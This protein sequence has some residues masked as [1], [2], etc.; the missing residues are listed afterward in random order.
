MYFL[1]KASGGFTKNLKKT[2]ASCPIIFPGLTD[3]EGLWSFVCPAG[4]YLY[5]DGFF[6]VVVFKCKKLKG[7]G[8]KA[9]TLDG[10]IQ[11]IAFG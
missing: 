8:P 3:M 9:K 5:S 11:K 2:L 1:Q 4:I 6:I 10:M 7:I